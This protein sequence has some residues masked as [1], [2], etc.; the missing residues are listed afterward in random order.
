MVESASSATVFRAPRDRAMLPRTYV[1]ARNASRVHD[2]TLQK[3]GSGDS[4]ERIEIALAFG[5]KSTG[6][7]RKEPSCGI[8]G[9]ANRCRVPED[10]RVGDNRKKLMEAGPG[11]GYRFRSAYGLGQYLASTL[12]KGHLG[13]MR[14]D[15]V[16]M[17]ISA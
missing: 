17:P 11:N 15:E 12:V 6:E 14:I 8:Q 4:L 10:P 2:R 1:A 9:H 5:Q 3:G 16:I 13:A 7:T